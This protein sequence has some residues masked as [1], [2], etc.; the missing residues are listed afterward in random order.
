M[1]QTT[2]PSITPTPLPAPQ[3]GDRATFSSR[4]DAFIVWLTTAVGQFSA[5]ATNVY[6]NAVDAFNSTAAAANSAATAAAQANAAQA[7]VGV[8][9]FNATKA[10]AAGEAAYSLINGQ[11]YRRITAGTNA[12]NPAND[13]TNWRVLSGSDSNGAFIPVAVAALNIDLSQGNYFTKSISA[14]STF[15]FS[16]TPTAGASFTFRLSLT[17]SVVVAFPSS[18][19][20][21]NNLPVQFVANKSY[22]LMFIT[23]DGGAR[24]RL[25]AAPNFDL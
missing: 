16:N 24:W 25:V 13:Q 4:V 17:A 7:T 19:R 22:L 1:A 23:D 21:P 6:N 15:T 5:L 3:R 11:T 10:Y 9:A 12:T 14:N 2:P 8:Q 18:V 20:T